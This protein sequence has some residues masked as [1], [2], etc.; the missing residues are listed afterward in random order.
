MTLRVHGKC[1]E[2]KSSALSSCSNPDFSVLGRLGQIKT[3]V[4]EDRGGEE[5][6]SPAFV[7]LCAKNI[8][9]TNGKAFLY[10]SSKQ[11]F[12]FGRLSWDW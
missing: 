6:E 4:R 5:D 11:W 9:S 2:A 10:F 8:K 7:I 3:E 1:I 12:R